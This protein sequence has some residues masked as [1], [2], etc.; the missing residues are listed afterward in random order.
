MQS[1]TEPTV[2]VVNV[3]INVQVFSTIFLQMDVAND[4]SLPFRL[5]TC[6]KALAYQWFFFHLSIGKITK[7]RQR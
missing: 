4:F 2:I 1:I 6:E 7:N 3:D 5:P